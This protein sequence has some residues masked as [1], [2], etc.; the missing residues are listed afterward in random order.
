MNVAQTYQP[1]CPVIS[2]FICCSVVEYVCCLLVFT[3]RSNVISL[4]TSQLPSIQ[5][6]F[7]SF[8]FVFTQKQFALKWP[9]WFCI[10]ID[11]IT[12]YTRDYVVTNDRRHQGDHTLGTFYGFEFWGRS[13]GRR[14]SSG[15]TCVRRN[16]DASRHQQFKNF[17]KQSVSMYVR[18]LQV[19]YTC[20]HS[21]TYCR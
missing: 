18:R 19:N 9:T 16:T 5:F 7:F 21:W 17:V 11:K 10:I 15:C 14:V 6:F 8:S 13:P 4:I 3:T 12:I 20:I 1:R 2:R